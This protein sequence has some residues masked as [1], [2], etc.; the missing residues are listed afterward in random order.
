MTH[1]IRLLRAAMASMALLV[2]FKLHG[3]VAGL[4]ATA[5]RLELV[6]AAQAEPAVAAAPAVAPPASAATIIA[7]LPQPSPEQ[8]AEQA[9]LEGLRARRLAID[10]REQAMA[11]RDV[12]LAAAERRLAQRIEELSALQQ[13]LEMAD[14]QRGEREDAGW[15]QLV[16][17]YEGMRPRAAATIFDELE[18]PVL[19]QV[20]DRM[21]EAKAAA[22]LGVMRPE[23]ARLL[24]TEL[25]RH[26]AR[27]TE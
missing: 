5:P 18:L 16:K 22:V 9:V 13:R 10:A 21:R 3:L 27:L 25:A 8:R 19:V 12:V 15:K 23:R 1:R 24:T 6:A 7:A 11:A 4:P 26:R 17:L 14:R 2:V 20:V